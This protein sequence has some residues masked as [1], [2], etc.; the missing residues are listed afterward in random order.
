MIVKF[1]PFFLFSLLIYCFLH[2]WDPKFFLKYTFFVS[3]Q[4]IF[5][6]FGIYN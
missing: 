5:V 6:I 1:L 4:R 2:F 3:L